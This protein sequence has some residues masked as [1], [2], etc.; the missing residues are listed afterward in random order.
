MTASE[1]AGLWQADADVLRR[2]GCAVQ[3][4]ALERCASE[5]Q[6]AL[7]A[8]NAEALTLAEAARESGYSPDRL[9]HLVTAGVI[10]NAGARGRPRIRRAD[11]PRKAKASAVGFDA[12][13]AADHVLSGRAR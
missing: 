12:I 2:R 6:A 8:E 10:P 13:A 3:A 11:L 7:R 4:E 1:L 9:R 5:L